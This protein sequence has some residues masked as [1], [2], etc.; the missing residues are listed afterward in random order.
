MKFEIPEG[1]GTE[2][3]LEATLAGELLWYYDYQN[4]IYVY[5]EGAI[6]MQMTMSMPMPGDAGGEMTTKGRMNIKTTVVE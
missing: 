1:A 6:E 2:G 5:G 3:S 4:S